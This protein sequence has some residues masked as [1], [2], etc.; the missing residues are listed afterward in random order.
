MTKP[1]DTSMLLVVALSAFM[2]LSATRAAS[3]L[4]ST[5]NVREISPPASVLEGALESNTDVFVFRERSNY[6]LPFGIVV[7]AANVGANI[8]PDGTGN[9][10][11][12]IPSGTTIESWYIH[13]DTVGQPTLP[14]IISWAITWQPNDRI[15]GIIYSD[16]RLNNSDFVRHPGTLYPNRV[17]FRGTTGFAEGDDLITFASPQGLIAQQAVTVVH[18]QMRV[19]FAVPEPTTIALG[20]LAAVVAI[21]KRSRNS[22]GQLLDRKA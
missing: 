12:V 11:G 1:L 22:E 18:D 3:I 6:T 19:I 17:Q 20:V 2:P 14:E 13:Y 21:C 5:P 7:D 16:D 10:T 15:L 4:T 8:L 9:L